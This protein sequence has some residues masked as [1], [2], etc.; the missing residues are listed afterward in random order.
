MSNRIMTST[1]FLPTLALVMA[2]GIP[3]A[4]AASQTTDACKTDMGAQLEMIRD[5]IASIEGDPPLEEAWEEVQ[6]D[7]GRLQLAT[8]QQWEERKEDLEMSLEQLEEELERV[9]Q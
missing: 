1:K 6:G 8:D 2:L 3:P 4:L 9:S 5:R 7:W